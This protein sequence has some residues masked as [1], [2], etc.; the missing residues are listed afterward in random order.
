MAPVGKDKVIG[1][2]PLEGPPID[3]E[4]T[5]SANL[6]DA[7]KLLSNIQEY[8]EDIQKISVSMKGMALMHNNMHAYISAQSAI[9][10][11]KDVL[12]IMDGK[13]ITTIAEM[14]EKVKKE[15]EEMKR[16]L[17]EAAEKEQQYTY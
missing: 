5:L 16:K 15:E 4:A 3:I 1:V 2:K 13:K 8:L 11:A 14:Q 12:D 6:Y 9:D 7:K 10:V 17:K